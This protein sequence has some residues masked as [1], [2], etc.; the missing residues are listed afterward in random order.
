M[1]FFNWIK[2]IHKQ[3]HTEVYDILIQENSIEN[4]I[5]EYGIY[6]NHKNANSALNF[7]NRVLLV[8]KGCAL[9]DYA[10]QPYE[11][12]FISDCQI[13]EDDLYKKSL[14]CTDDTIL[15]CATADV[16]RQYM[17]DHNTGNTTVKDY[18]DAYRTYAKEY[19]TA[20]GGYGGRFLD[21]VYGG[22][23]S[24]SCGNGSAMRVSPCGCCVEQE[25]VITQAY[26][27]AVCTHS[28]P[29]GIKGAIVTAMCVWMAFQGCSKE[30]I[31]E[32]ASKYY[33]DSPYSPEI[34]F[35][36]MENYNI[37]QG[38]PA[39]CQSTVPLAVS[40]FVNSESFEDCITKA[41]R[42][43]LDTDTQAAIAGSIAAAYYQA[44]DKK[45]E[46]AWRKI[47]K[48][49]PYIKKEIKGCEMLKL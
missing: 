36:R 25:T 24:N 4:F 30:K 19:P 26:L 34:L 12:A 1:N 9:G 29:E 40:C 31:G 44:F 32:Y 10:G 35:Q 42:F 14:G 48:E 46:D 22:Q 41:I 15:T 16:I 11:G 39:V 27:S 49:S 17:Y 23:E 8:L 7:V 18:A 5:K 33:K 21:W 3:Y 2:K 45:S 38:N 43:G 6:H 28:H 47:T 37:F 20:L 13:S